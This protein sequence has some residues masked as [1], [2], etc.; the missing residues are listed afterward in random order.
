MRK[1]DTVGS[2]LERNGY[3]FFMKRRAEEDQWSIYCRKGIDGHDEVIVDPHPFSPDHSASVVA[4][5]SSQDASMLT[6]GVRQGGV[7]R[8]RFACST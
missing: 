2:P 5:S 7:E 4:Y 8:R 1:H 6:Y 3:Y